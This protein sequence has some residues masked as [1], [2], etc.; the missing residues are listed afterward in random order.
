MQEMPLIDKTIKRFYWSRAWHESDLPYCVI[1]TCKVPIKRYLKP[2][3][4]L[5]RVSLCMSVPYWWPA[6]GLA[7]AFQWMCSAGPLTKPTWGKS[8]A[9]RLTI[10]PLK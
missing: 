2:C 1:A 7:L 10:E 8:V 3:D 4:A 9:A 6:T 5:L